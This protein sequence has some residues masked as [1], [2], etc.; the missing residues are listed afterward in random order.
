MP[1]EAIQI[2]ADPE[3]AALILH[4]LRLRI[5]EALAEPASASTLSGPLGVPRQHLNYHLRELEKAGLVEFVEERRKGN[6]VER[7]Y[8][9]TARSYVIS[10][11]AL[12]SVNASPEKVANRRSAE[13]LV[14]LGSRLIEDTAELIAAKKAPPTLALETE[15]AFATDEERAQFAQELAAFATGLAQR[16]HKPSDKANP[17][18]ILIAAHPSTRKEGE[19]L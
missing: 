8:R 12:G 15:I 9:S 3:S 5:L 16:Y 2:I 19:L 11:A 14:A 7:R 4:P 18:R 10:P 6:C 13:Y 17:Y 1:A